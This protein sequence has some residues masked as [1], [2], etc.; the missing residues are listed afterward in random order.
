M[1]TQEGVGNYFVPHP[2]R[3][4]VNFFPIEDVSDYIWSI[5]LLFGGLTLSTFWGDFGVLAWLLF[6]VF[7]LFTM[8]PIFPSKDERLYYLIFISPF[9]ELF[10]VY[11]KGVIWK[12]GQKDKY[13]YEVR[14]FGKM[15]LIYNVSK[16]TY[17]MVFRMTGSLASTLSL[18]GQYG[19]NASIAEIL[20]RASASTGL[21]G[22]QV[23]FGYSVRPENPFAVRYE[24]AERGDINVI[25]PESLMQEKPEE[26]YTAVD[27][28]EI[29]LR[30][31]ANE[32]EMM[33]LDGT[34][35]TMVYVVTIN[36][37]R[38]FRRILRQGEFYSQQV[39][40][41]SLIRIKETLTTLLRTVAQGVEMLNG[42]QAE[43]YLRQSRDVARAYEYYGLVNQR[44]AEGED[45]LTKDEQTKLLHAPSESITANADSLTMD[46]TSGTVIRLTEF[47]LDQPPVNFVREYSS[48]FDLP[49]PFFSVSITG[50]TKKGS[51]Q[52]FAKSTGNTF[53]D[54]ARSV[55]G[56]EK[57]G[58]AQQELESEREDEERRLRASYTID[59]RPSVAILAADENKSRDS[60]DLQV[61]ATIDQLREKGLGPVHVTGRHR[62][63]NEVLS[64]ITHIP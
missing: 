56:R 58:L 52:S 17:S 40:R 27:R 5:V 8:W 57:K 47:P 63:Y 16:G 59:F 6:G 61:L 25:L 4:R 22:L 50:K 41:Q 29:F 23:T 3:M 43:E 12:K 49:A 38:V 55:T 35:V 14:E 2:K 28:R 48:V 1:S 36:D 34:L 21:K 26:E 39:R 45:T 33:A 37:S 20:R 11:K 19:N 42:D 15:G 53:A 31:I 10:Q 60:L 51:V 54:A 46:G 9:R 62:Q 18:V 64:T 13:P 44:A 32:M 24:L 30:Q 7:W